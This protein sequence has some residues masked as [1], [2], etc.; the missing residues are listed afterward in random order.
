MVIDNGKGL[1]AWVRQQ[2]ENKKNQSLPQIERLPSA[3]I[4]VDF[5][6]HSH[7][8]SSF[9]TFISRPTVTVYPSP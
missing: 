1:S 4:L 3:S 9:P 7:S 2:T 8:V 5:Y 6:N